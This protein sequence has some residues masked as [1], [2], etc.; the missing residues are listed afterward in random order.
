MD[1]DQTDLEVSP[2]LESTSLPTSGSAAISSSSINP[3]VSFKRKKTFHE[4]ETERKAEALSEIL[5]L[6]DEFAPIIP[7]SVTD[8]H[9]ARSG[10]QCDDV[11]VK[12]LLALATQKFISDIATDAMHY[13]KLRQ[14]AVQG[15]ER[16]QTLKDK[17]TVL[18][19]DDLAAAMSEQ[20]VNIKKP[21]YY[22]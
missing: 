8:H 5:L 21:D 10:F 13:S 16:R 1:L 15:K 6:M 14:Q 11:R 9:L 3:A 19:M 4:Q 2:K 22:V 7:D 12:R 20:G 17:R 18:T